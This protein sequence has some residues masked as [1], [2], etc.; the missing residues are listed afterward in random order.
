[1]EKC[2]GFEERLGLYGMCDHLRGLPESSGRTV[3]CS[4]QAHVSSAYTNRHLMSRF[5]LQEQTG[6]PL[7]F[8]SVCVTYASDIP[9]YNSSKDMRACPIA[10]IS[11]PKDMH[12]ISHHTLYASTFRLIPNTDRCRIQTCKLKFVDHRSGVIR[13][14]NC[15]PLTSTVTACHETGFRA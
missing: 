2:R 13:A 4:C 11:W 14:P 1:M 6:D 7:A 5:L 8:S 3:H 15:S 10:A 12:I 9:V